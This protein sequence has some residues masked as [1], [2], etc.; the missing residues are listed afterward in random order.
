[1][2]HSRKLIVVLL[3]AGPLIA[4]Y[5][6]AGQPAQD[7]H[8]EFYKIVRTVKDILLGQNTE[9]AKA[10][11]APGAQLIWGAKFVDLGDVVAGK[12]TT[13][14]LADTSFHGVMIQARTNETEDMG[15]VIL[16]TRQSDTT[17]VRFHSVVFLK[18]S[19]GRYR[20]H[21]WHSGI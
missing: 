12:N 2:S 1:M 10:G 6:V 11:I 8:E 16:K 20:I 21:H 13:C 14:P 15:W 18:D 4:V 17:K 7:E 3:L 5:S 19:T 9:Q